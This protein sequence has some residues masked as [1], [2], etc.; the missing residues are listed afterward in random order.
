MFGDIGWTEILVIGIVALIVG[1][2]V[3]VAVFN[4]QTLESVP[5]F[6]YLTASLPSCFAAG[7]VHYVLTRIFAKGEGWGNYPRG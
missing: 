5:A 7:L 6:K 1:F 4:P 2:V 3:Y